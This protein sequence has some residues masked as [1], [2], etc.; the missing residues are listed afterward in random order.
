MA[1]CL[2]PWAGFAERLGLP[3]ARPWPVFEI[4]GVGTLAFAALLVRAARGRD[5][6]TIARAASAPAARS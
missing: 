5:T 2:S 1:L 6:I 3:A 4:L